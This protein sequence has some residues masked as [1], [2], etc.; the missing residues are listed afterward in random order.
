MNIW[1]RIKQ[2]SIK[3]LLQLAFLFA[4]KPLYIQ[5]TIRATKE[6][7]KLCDAKF[8]RAH[9]KSNRSNAFRHAL[10]NYLICRNI[11]K[12]AKNSQKAL[13]WA[14]KVTK[15]YEKV[16]NNNILDE[17]MDLHNNEIGR[18]V[19]FEQK[20]LKLTEIDRFL[21]EKLQKAIKIV[22]IEDINNAEGQLVYILE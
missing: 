3:Q 10:W 9:H 14:E 8:G 15:T 6:T 13:I 19:F 5:P 4:R 2:L 1:V 7:M 21:E 22:Q 18:K 12:I 17:V 11:L 16:T 20:S